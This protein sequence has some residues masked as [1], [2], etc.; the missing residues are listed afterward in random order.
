MNQYMT[1]IKKQQHSTRHGTARHGN[2]CSP[3]KDRDIGV[4][5]L[6]RIHEGEHTLRHSSQQ[7]GF[8]RVQEDAPLLQDGR[9]QLQHSLGSQRPGSI[10]RRRSEVV[11]P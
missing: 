1:R 3:G 6:Q 4:R 2:N 5:P 9:E 10:K 8:R 7:G 11:Y